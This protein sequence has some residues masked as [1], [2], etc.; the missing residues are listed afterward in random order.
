MFCSDQTSG[1]LPAIC[2]GENHQGKGRSSMDL[3]VLSSSVLR[4]RSAQVIGV[5]LAMTAC[6]GSMRANVLTATTA[7]VTCNTAT[8]PGTAGTI[9]IKPFP[10]LTGSASIVVTFTPPGGGLTVTAPTLT[11]L[12]TTNQ[13]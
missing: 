6:A 9:T 12:R 13:S 2:R 5:L 3:S 4:K 1:R 8:G 11:T 7:A 10:L